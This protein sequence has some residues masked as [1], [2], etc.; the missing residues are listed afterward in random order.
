MGVHLN[1]LPACSPGYSIDPVRQ[2]HTPNR[3]TEGR[4]SMR[5]PVGEC[6]KSSTLQ[7]DLQHIQQNSYFP[8]MQ[9]IHSVEH[10][11]FNGFINSQSNND[12]TIINYC[13]IMYTFLKN[14]VKNAIYASV[15][16][17]QSLQSENPQMNYAEILNNARNPCLTF[18]TVDC[19]LKIRQG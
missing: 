2:T 11:N 19:S 13:R 9:I 18:R 12:T 14:S 16:F 5:L 7:F 10:R 1:T 8:L 3:H 15:D 4:L 6:R 17:T